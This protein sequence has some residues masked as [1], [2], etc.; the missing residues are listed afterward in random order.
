LEDLIQVFYRFIEIAFDIKLTENARNIIRQEMTNAWMSN[1]LYFMQT[2]NYQVNVLLPQ[3]MSVDP[4]SL[5]TWR[6]ANIPQFVAGLRSNNF[7]P[8]SRAIVE[9]YD[10]K[11]QLGTPQGFTGYGQNFERSKFGQ[12]T[13]RQ[14]NIGGFSQQSMGNQMSIVGRWRGEV[15]IVKFNEDHQFNQ[16]MTWKKTTTGIS[17]SNNRPFMTVLNGRYQLSGS[18]LVIRT[19]DESFTPMDAP[20]GSGMVIRPF[21]EEE[22]Y[23]ISLQNNGQILVL[24]GLNVN[25]KPNSITLYRQQG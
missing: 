6:S 8:M 21:E 9:L 7:D 17:S 13:F 12:Q 2:V 3:L 20:V 1:N 16:D 25:A 18:Q 10:N 11:Q 24:E 5:S 19:T 23:A 15:P 14:P 4:M 22:V